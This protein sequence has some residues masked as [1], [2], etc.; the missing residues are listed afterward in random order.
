M[1]D[2]RT[3]VIGV[4]RNWNCIGGVVGRPGQITQV[5]AAVPDHDD[6]LRRTIDQ[7]GVERL[8]GAR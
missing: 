7:S 6:G 4:G 5:A 1:P 8:V 2:H 3:A